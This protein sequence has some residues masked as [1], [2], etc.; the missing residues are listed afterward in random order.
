MLCKYQSI[1]RNIV[2]P[3]SDSKRCQNLENNEEN[4][5]VSLN[6]VSSHHER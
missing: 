1:A 5:S 6:Q 4:V 2:S 3:S